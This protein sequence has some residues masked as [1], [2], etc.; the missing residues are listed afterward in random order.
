MKALFCAA[1]FLAFLTDEKIVRA[2]PLPSYLPAPNGNAVETIV[3]LRHG[4]KPE[5]EIRLK[6]GRKIHSTVEYENIDGTTKLR[7]PRPP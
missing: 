2:D 4:E 1:A 6:I 7:R 3:F 5:K